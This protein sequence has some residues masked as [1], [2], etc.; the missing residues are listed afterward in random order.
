[1]W[2]SLRNIGILAALASCLMGAE[3]PRANGEGAGW[4][5]H[6]LTFEMTAAQILDQLN[7]DRWKDSTRHPNAFFVRIEHIE[8]FKTIVY[9]KFPATILVPTG[10]KKYR[11]EPT[12]AKNIGNVAPTQF[13][14]LYPDR[15]EFAHYADLL[16]ERW[17]EPMGV[18]Q[19]NT[20]LSAAQHF[21]LGSSAV[22]SGEQLCWDSPDGSYVGCLSQVDKSSEDVRM[23]LADKA[24]GT[25]RITTLTILR[26]S[27][28]A[29]SGGKGALSLAH[30][31]F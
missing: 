28:L 26:K 5:P 15:F 25:D 11:A 17:G 27:D 19:T 3:P 4:I 9:A 22:I 8:G 6:G 18:R 14:F 2:K 20:R 24:L 16:V 13:I 7:A 30:L 29:T 1:M 21:F 31:G 10:E 12:T 23:L